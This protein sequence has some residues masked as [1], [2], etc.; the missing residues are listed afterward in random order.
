[1]LDLLF[2]YFLVLRYLLYRL[3]FLKELSVRFCSIIENEFTAEIKEYLL[4]ITE[5]KSILLK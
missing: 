5:S 2:D 4:L 3:F 1:M